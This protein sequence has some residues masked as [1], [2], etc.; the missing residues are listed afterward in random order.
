MSESSETRRSTR[1]W[2]NCAAAAAWKI[3]LPALI[4]VAQRK[5]GGPIT[6]RSEDRNLA[7]ILRDMSYLSAK[8][9]FATF[10]PQN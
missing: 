7:L 2:E 10:T 8:I 9:A 5:R 4:R 3:Q 6:H 1:D